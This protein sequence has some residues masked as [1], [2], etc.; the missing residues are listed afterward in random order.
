M[1]GARTK[2]SIAWMDRDFTKGTPD[3]ATMLIGYNNRSGGQSAEM[4]RKQLEIWIDHL[5]ARTN[6]KTAII[7]IPTLPGIPRWYGQDDM[8]K[9]VYEVAQKYNCTVVPLEKMIKKMGPFAYRKNYLADGVHPNQAGHKL[10]AEEIVKYF[11]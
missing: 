9:M 3:V 7:L 2:D 4:Y 10:F 8:A 11:K 5:L 6:G 1:G